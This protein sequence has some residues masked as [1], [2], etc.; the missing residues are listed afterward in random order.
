MPEMKGTD[1]GRELLIVILN[2][3]GWKDTLEC[4]SSLM[5]NSW[6]NFTVMIV[7]NGSQDGSIQRIIDWSRGKTSIAVGPALWKAREFSIPL[8]TVSLSDL[9]EDRR[10][11][12]PS[13]RPGILL[14]QNKENVGFARGANIG[15]QYGLEQGFTYCLLLNNDTTLSPGCLQYLLAE[16]AMHP[17]YAAWA[18]AIYYYDNPDVLW[19][20]GGSLTLTG[21]R[22]L[23]LTGKTRHSINKSPRRIS[24]ISGCALMARTDIFSSHGLLSERFFFGEEDYE[25]SKRMKKAGIALAVTAKAVLYHKVGMTNRRLF[26]PNNLSYMFIGY[27]NRFIHHKTYFPHRLLWK[28]WRSLCLIY[29][30]PKLI[31]WHKLPLTTAREFLHTLILFSNRYDTVDSELVR[32]AGKLFS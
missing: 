22:K 21:R 7:D 5:M 28:A 17:E 19:M 32:Q 12:H 18:P 29:I 9:Q 14:V 15:I 4:L 20:Y 27:L 25:F 8:T 26:G 2:W 16:S 10:S 11:L 13:E 23:D 1:P 24:F 6:Q 3:N 31:L 30:M